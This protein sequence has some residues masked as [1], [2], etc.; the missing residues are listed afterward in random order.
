VI[1]RLRTKATPTESPTLKPHITDQLTS[2]LLMIRKG[3]LALFVQVLISGMNFVLSLLLARWL[4]A[5]QYGAYT[6]AFSVFLVISSVHNGLLLEPM[7]VLG[8]A[9][10][11]K[12]LSGYVGK[13][14]RLHFA[15]ATG[16]AIA[17]AIA[18]AAISRLPH[19]AELS[20]ALAGACLAAP[21]V[22]FL[23][24]ARQAAYLEMR[25]DIAV[26]GAITYAVAILL[27]IFGLHAFGQLTPFGAFL[28]LAV[29]GV[30]G[31]VS[32]MVQ[33]RPK[34]R[35]SP[36]DAS[37][38]TIWKQHWVYGRWV[39]VTSFVYWVSGQAAY[40][41]IAAAFLKM[42]DVGTISAL[43][44]L[45]AP[46]SQFLTALSLLLLPWASTQLAGK[47]VAAFQ[48]GIRRITLLFTGAGISY[49]IFV[50]GFGRQLTALLYHGKYTQSAGLIPMLAL[51]Q[52]FMAVS[53]GPVMGLRAMQRPSRIFVGYS[54]AA[55]FSIAVGFALT[56][57]W[58][59]RGN[60]TGMA[61]SSLCFLVAT[62]Y[63][64]CSEKKRQAS[65]EVSVRDMDGSTTRVAWLLPSMDRGSCWQPLFKEFAREFPHTIVFTGLWNGYLRGYEDSF[66]LRCVPGY[67]FITLKK[68]PE[69]YGR[70][71][72]WAP[73]RVIPELY[74]FRPNVIFTSG[75]S[76]WTLYALVF[77]VFTD[78]RVII[79]WEGS[80]P[81]TD[82]RD[83]R[84]R[85]KVRK[86]MARFAD[87]GVSNMRA[88]VEYL[89]TVIGMSNSKLLHH[90][91]EVPDSSVLCS[92]EATVG[93]GSI[94]RPAFLF[95][96]SL[97]G[98]K[99]WSSLI[100]AANLL[101]NRGVDS[102]SVVLVGTG[103]QAEELNALVRSHG[104]EQHIYQVGK[105]A[106]Q[107][108]GSY[109][110]AADVFVFPTHQD[111]WGL[112]LLE[113]MAFGKPVLCSMNAGSKEMVTHG[114]NGFIFDPSNPAELADYMAQLVGDPSLIARFGTCASEAVAPYT[115]V[116]A[117]QA[118][119]G[120][121]RGTIRP[122][123]DLWAASPLR[124]AG[125]IPELTSD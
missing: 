58:G 87:G 21:W 77:K 101:A 123:Q 65:R 49:F 6:L 118:L 52:V 81:T 59:V 110:R 104:L 124:Q 113:A 78:A 119:A 20:G 24:F 117:A 98:R 41:F 71:F 106:Y 109:Y 15:L 67:R 70:G 105:V 82:C 14:I 97:I 107:N 86:L 53:Q 79:L 120:L 88:G 39:V 64:Y 114:E 32:L 121:T 57:Y 100:E 73:M 115:P 5:S 33:I 2:A 103:D 75:F 23:W 25:P 31:G 76:L 18:G 63:C 45:V 102:F 28:T 4:V 17:M 34:F 36:T 37:F 54:V 38:A 83:S 7:G 95:V 72:F 48:R 66:R 74:A 69:G 27:M 99:G 43:Q 13:L 29:A 3:S 89:N 125:T 93:L 84:L 35:S 11:G 26:K 90:P 8:P 1:L 10:H 60:V 116:R 68:D 96:G 122:L 62:A 50:V 22:L 51:S 112:V 42:G 111:T 91:Y 108:L 19:F 94:R 44:N 30:V 80:S 47:D 16:L 40:Y 85:L 61:A 92:G 12:S 9:L 46:L 56:R 55:A